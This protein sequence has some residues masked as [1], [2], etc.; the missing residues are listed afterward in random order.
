MEKYSFTWDQLGDISLG[1]PNLGKMTT[2]AVY[3][4]MHYTMRA[5][6]EGELGEAETR[7]IFVKA[8]RMAG[9]EFC[10][11]MLD[12]SLPLNKFL[13]QLHEKL[14]ENF[15]GVMKVE[16]QDPQIMNF[17]ITVSEDLDCSGLPIQGFTVC[18]YD[19]GFLE[20]IFNEYTKKDYTA[21]EI[22]CWSTGERTCRF[23]VRQIE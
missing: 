16:K 22:D 3:R 1:R 20:G 10:K 18:D 7:L 2:V 21:K 17:V 23:T 15:I 13:A 12:I 8:G 14:I 6:L 5:V 9:S 11:H 19:E 4:L